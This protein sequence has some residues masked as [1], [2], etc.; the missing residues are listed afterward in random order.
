MK[1]NFIADWELEPLSFKEGMRVGIL[2]RISEARVRKGGLL[3]CRTE[4]KEYITY[5]LFFLACM[6]AQNKSIYT[7]QQRA[8]EI[9]EAKAENRIPNLGG[10]KGVKLTPEEILKIKGLVER[11]YSV[12]D[13]TYVLQFKNPNITEWVIRKTLGRV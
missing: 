10:L 2:E 13:I 7:K 6:E 11:G 5:S 4:F 8:R 1:N 3:D 9:K 12:A